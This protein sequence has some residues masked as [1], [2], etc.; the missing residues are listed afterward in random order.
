MTD[1]NKDDG[2]PD[3][4]INVDDGIVQT[5]LLIVGAGPAGASLACF[6]AQHG[7]AN[8]NTT[9][10]LELR[11]GRSERNYAGFHAH[12]RRYPSSTYNEH[13][14]TGMSAGYRS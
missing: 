11:S 7:K 14:S 3:T 6:L 2:R 13:G 8:D 9:R 5:D 12:H 4:K 10:V 1:N